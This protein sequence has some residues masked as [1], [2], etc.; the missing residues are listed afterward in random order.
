MMIYLDTASNRKGKPNE[1]FARE[2]MELFTLGEGRYTEHDINEAARA[3]TGWTLDPDTGEFVFRP[4]LHDDGAKTVLGRTGS[5]D[6]DAVLDILLAQPATGR[7]RRRE[8]VA[9]VRLARARPGGGE[10]H[11]R[12]FPGRATTRSRSRCASCSC[13][14][15]SGRR[16]TAAR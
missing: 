8:A 7:V 16:R 3:F 4:A 9:R 11:R 5:F 10:A 12:A 15:R 1:N 2:V 6:G 13:P 14:R